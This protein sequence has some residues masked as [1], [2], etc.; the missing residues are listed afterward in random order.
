MTGAGSGL[1]R[2]ICLRLARDGWHL[3]LADVDIHGA[4]E[5]L[6]L[7]REAGGDGRVEP[8]DVT[9]EEQW[10]SLKSR[11]QE[12][13]PQLDLLVNNAGIG[14]SGELGTFS[15]EQWRRVMDVNLWGV[16]YG[17]HCMVDWLKQNP[18]GAHLI[19]TASFAALAT[20][21]S[22]GGYN[23]SKAGVL[24]LS[25]TLYGELQPYGIGVTVICPLF[26]RTN[27][28]KDW[29]AGSEIE[30]RAAEFYTDQADFTAEDV[31][32]AAVR[33]MQRKQLYVIMGRKARWY[34]RMKRLMPR[35]FLKLISY[36]YSSW[37]KNAAK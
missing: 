28:L 27:L 9:S 36:K 12:D 10:T 14:A 20:A 1:G 16:I 19:N 13:W 23:V 37:V 26:F 21:P 15:L 30:R 22:M 32:N 11:L 7:V 18:H 29:P 3:A 34:W 2:A 5:T 31:A 25:E 4:A 17:C 35:T 6:R 33:A 24:A 8:L